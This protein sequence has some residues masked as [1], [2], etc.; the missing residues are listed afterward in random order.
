L[1]LSFFGKL[2]LA[3]PH[4]ADRAKA[5]ECGS[6]YFRPFFPSAKQKETLVMS[7]IVTLSTPPTQFATA[8]KSEDGLALLLY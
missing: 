1:R 2:S 8:H 7:A 3:T 4:S 5:F 6:R